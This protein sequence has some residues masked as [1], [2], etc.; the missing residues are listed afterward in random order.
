LTPEYCEDYDYKFHCSWLETC[1]IDV[2]YVQ[3][4]LTY[5]FQSL[6]Q[7]GMR[8]CFTARSKHKCQFIS[9]WVVWPLIPI[10]VVEWASRDTWREEF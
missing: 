8:N 10:G 4:N 3:L 5:Q 1:S 6:L 7:M 2:T 9:L